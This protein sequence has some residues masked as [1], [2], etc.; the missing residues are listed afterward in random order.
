MRILTLEFALL[1]CTALLLQ[2]GCRHDDE[3]PK[4]LRNSF[5]RKYFAVIFLHVRSDGVSVIDGH[6]LVEVPVSDAW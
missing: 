1:C 6:V 3:C 2:I 4:K 5:S